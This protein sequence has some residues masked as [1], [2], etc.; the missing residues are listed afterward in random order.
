MSEYL[1]VFVWVCKPN[2][3]PQSYS[4]WAFGC[5]LPNDEIDI[6]R[7]RTVLYMKIMN[8]FVLLVL[9]VATASE[10]SEF[11]HAIFANA[12]QASSQLS[13]SIVANALFSFQMTITGFPQENLSNPRS[14]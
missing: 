5:L 7:D 8:K 11:P 13:A 10:S 1:C 3:W 4:F 14:Q 9:K 12:Q 2:I 6:N